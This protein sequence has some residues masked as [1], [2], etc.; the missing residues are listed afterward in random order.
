MLKIVAI[1]MV[2]GGKEKE[3]FCWLDCFSL[4]IIILEYV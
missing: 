2:L 1:C 3:R 4:L